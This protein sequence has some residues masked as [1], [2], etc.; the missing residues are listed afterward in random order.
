[1]VELKLREND[2]VKDINTS[3]VIDEIKQIIKE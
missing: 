3:D 1:M 2:I